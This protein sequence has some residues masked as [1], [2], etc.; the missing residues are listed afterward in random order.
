MRS[1]TKNK[2]NPTSTKILTTRSKTEIE[3]LTKIELPTKNLCFVGISAL[4][5]IMKSMNIGEILDPQ[6]PIVDFPIVDSVMDGK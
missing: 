6:Y 1:K 2:V 3:L 5:E 4:I